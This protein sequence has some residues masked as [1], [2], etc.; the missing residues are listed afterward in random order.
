MIPYNRKPSLKY[1]TKF[2][3]KNSFS[4]HIIPKTKGLEKIYRFGGNKYNPPSVQVHWYGFKYHF[5]F[6]KIRSEDMF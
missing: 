4:P 2:L 6:D 3:K 1:S 5:C